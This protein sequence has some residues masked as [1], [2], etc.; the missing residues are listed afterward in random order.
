MP[1]F[2]SMHAAHGPLCRTGPD[3]VP[4]RVATGEQAQCRS[5]YVHAKLIPAAV[6]RVS[7][8]HMVKAGL[9]PVQQEECNTAREG[10]QE[11][12]VGVNCKGV[13]GVQLQ[14][15]RLQGTNEQTAGPPGGK[16]P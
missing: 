12:C 8:Y 13:G 5:Y 6:C 3:A 4:V 11:L 1:L 7:T 16:L 9:S 2:C 14:S 15:M 10:R